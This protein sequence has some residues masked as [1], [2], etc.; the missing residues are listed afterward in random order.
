MS[1]I[2]RETYPEPAVSPIVENLDAGARYVIH[3]GLGFALR[4][5]WA[6]VRL[7][8]SLRAHA[9]VLRVLSHPEFRGLPRVRP[10]LP[11]KY[12]GVYVALGLP[13]RTR[14]AILVTHYEFLRRHFVDGFLDEV[15]E[16]PP[17][18]WQ[19]T[20]DDREFRIHLDFPPSDYEG[21]LRLLFTMDG[22]EIYRLI[23]VFAPGAELGSGDGPVMVVSNI[24]GA[25]DFDRV[26]VAT[27]V[28]HDVQP[29]NLLMAALNGVAESTGISRLVGFHNSRMISGGR[30]L[31]FSYEKFFIG[32]G[33]EPRD[34][35]S[36]HVAL[37]YAEKPV[38][39]V[40]SNHRTRTLRK[41]QFKGDIQSEVAAAVRRR[42]K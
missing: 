28:C 8:C 1:V 17:V 29:S 21:D 15:L 25:Q 4:K 24:Q 41:R 31:F 36:Y 32:Y 12:F 5:T 34:G 30:E 6:A 38:T 37:P 9:K 3:R 40:K 27:K 18:L 35:M 14:R 33:G 16:R 7:L 19:Q 20:L 26:K 13:L 11:F 42:L 39:E 2:D 22:V 10:R 23:F